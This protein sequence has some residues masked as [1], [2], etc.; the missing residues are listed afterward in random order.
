MSTTTTP[1]AVLFLGATGG[2]GFSTLRRSLEAGHTCIALCRTPSKLSAK[3]PAEL[4]NKVKLEQGNAHDAS[5]VARCLINPSDPSRVVDMVITSIGGAFS[6]KTGI[7]DAH[8]CEKGAKAL[9]EALERVRKSG[10]T[11]SPRIV[12]VSSTGISDAGRDI[13]LL[14]VP[15]YKGLL[16]VPHKD[17]KMLEELLVGSGEQWT[18]VRPAFLTD[19]PAVGKVRAGVEDLVAHKFEKKEIGYTISREDVGKWM[20]ENLVEERDAKWVRKAVTL[21][22]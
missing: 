12:G 7:D 9:L 3:L 4:R 6:F 10:A 22:Y 2:C 16:A 8:V 21:A 19:G 18:I 17:K 5:A 15:L 13:P 1:K 20:F 14:M 11:G